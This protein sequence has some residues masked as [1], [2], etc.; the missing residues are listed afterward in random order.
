MSDFHNPRIMITG[1][2]GFV[3]SRAMQHYPSAIPV[4]GDALKLLGGVYN[5]GSENPL[6][7]LETA[8]AIWEA[9]V[10]G[11]KYRT[12][13]VRVTIFGRIARRVHNA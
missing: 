9:F 6:N 4:S 2:H 3:G 1:V 7:M 12:R 11:R 10:V 5:Y 13:A 8:Q